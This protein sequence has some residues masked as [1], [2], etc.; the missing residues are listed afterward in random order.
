[1]RRYFLILLILLALPSG[2]AYAADELSHHPASVADLSCFSILS[3][4]AVATLPANR[5]AKAHEG[6]QAHSTCDAMCAAQGAACVAV[7]VHDGVD[8]CADIMPDFAG[9]RCCTVAR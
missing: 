3:P 1:M 6:W 8:G 4:A 2:S 7:S 9:C 5:A